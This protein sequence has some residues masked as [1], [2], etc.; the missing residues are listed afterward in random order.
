MS[1]KTQMVPSTYMVIYLVDRIEC[2][3]GTCDLRSMRVMDP[4]DFLILVNVI[5]IMILLKAI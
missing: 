3:M 4:F 1:D 5:E 2:G